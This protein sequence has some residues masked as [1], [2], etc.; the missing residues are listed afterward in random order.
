MKATIVFE[1][2]Y[3]AVQS[4]KYRYII[5]V[6][7]S[8]SSKTISLIQLH[9]VYALQNKDK[10]LTI[11]R[12]TKHDCRQT[13]LEDAKRYLR[14]NNLYEKGFKVN[15]TEGKFYYDNNSSVEFLGTDDEE[16]IHGL[17]Q[18]CIWLN[19]PYNIS[20]TTFNQ[21]DQRTSDFVFIDYNPK[22]GHWVEKLLEREDS[23]V[24]H[25]TFKDNP[26]CPPN[27]RIKIQSYQPISMSE[28]VLNGI[29]TEQEANQYSF[30]NNI[31]ELNEIQL[32]EL[33][34]CILNEKQNSADLFNWQVYGLGL[35]SE[36]PNRIFKWTEIS[37]SE[38]HNLDVPI[39]YGCD[40]GAVDPWAIIEAKYYDGCLYVHE[41][42]YTSENVIRTQIDQFT[43]NEI[44][45]HSVNAELEEGIVI[46]MFNKLK[47][48][49]NRPIICDSNRVNKIAI[50]RRFDY[51]A[52]VAYKGTILDRIDLLNNL[53]VYYTKSSVNIFQEQEN[54][55]RKVDRY[56]IVL[57]EPE[58][59]DNHTMDA[60]GYIAMYLQ[61]EEIIRR[62]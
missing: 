19:E 9:H 5:N 53:K 49:K 6:G 29:L 12:D 57:D 47:V 39:Y 62:V 31:K 37:D 59:K 10:R 30:D 11:W 27:Q 48:N 51:T 4:K 61:R 54:Y 44:N 52:E 15:K 25:S 35:K 42:N 26:F 41:L 3:E 8:R 58:D 24:I 1:K 28:V 40:W 33:Q 43:R 38:Y 18:D 56:G 7:S 50:L 32:K 55:S 17:T 14:L 23:L 45:N 2:N 20:E 21:L 46:W 22:R 16:K 60:I 36:K 13:I 34:R